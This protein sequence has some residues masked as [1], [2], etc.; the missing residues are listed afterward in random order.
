MAVMWWLRPRVGIALGLTSAL[1][2]SRYVLQF[3]ARSSN[4]FVIRR[5]PGILFSSANLAMMGWSF[6]YF[7]RG[8][9]G[10]RWCSS[11]Y[12][13]PPQHHVLKGLVVWASRVLRN[14]LSTKSGLKSS[15]ISSDWCVAVVMIAVMRPE[16]RMCPMTIFAGMMET[17]IA[18]WRAMKKSSALADLRG[19][20][21]RS[22]LISTLIESKRQ[23][24]KSVEKGAG[25]AKCWI[26]R[27]Q[28]SDCSF[29]ART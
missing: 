7:E 21:F 11:W 16:S 18:Q 23:M 8:M 3:S 25:R 9:D 27:N 14:W 2:A 4:S 24:R 19:F 13:M 17:T 28:E 29:G 10:K 15:N 20:F 6:G 5:P 26:L 22:S 1:A 12:C